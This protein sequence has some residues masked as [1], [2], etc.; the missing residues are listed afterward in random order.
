MGVVIV[1]EVEMWERRERVLEGG[2]MRCG[3]ERRRVIVVV[4]VVIRSDG[5]KSVGNGVWVKVGIVRK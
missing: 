2:D 1:I 4:K 3:G 5:V